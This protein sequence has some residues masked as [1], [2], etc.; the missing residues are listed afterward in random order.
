MGK[1]LAWTPMVSRIDSHGLVADWN[2]VQR[3]SQKV[4]VGDQ[5]VDVN[6]RSG[7]ANELA[8]ALQ[9]QGAQHLQTRDGV[10]TGWAV[11]KDETEMAF[12]VFLCI[13][14]YAVRKIIKALLSHCFV[15]RGKHI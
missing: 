13:I 15:I 7:N 9:A 12:V 11:R 10:Y 14:S 1:D 5:I 8:S 4:Q 2:A 3:M 6:G